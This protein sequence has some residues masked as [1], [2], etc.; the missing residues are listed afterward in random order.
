MILEKFD[1]GEVYLPSDSPTAVA[2]FP[3][4]DMTRAVNLIARWADS[5]SQAKPKFRLSRLKIPAALGL[6]ALR[7]L[8]NNGTVTAEVEFQAQSPWAKDF[9]VAVTTQHM[10]EK[11]KRVGVD[12]A[13]SAY[14]HAV[15]L[16]IRSSYDILHRYPVG[17]E[18]KFVSR[19]SL[20][21]FKYIP[22]A[23]FKRAV[24]EIVLEFQTSDKTYFDL[25]ELWASVWSRCSDLH[26]VL[27]KDAATAD[28]RA[29][30]YL[31]RRY[32]VAPTGSYAP[33]EFM[34]VLIRALF[35]DKRF[36]GEALL[37]YSN[38]KGKTGP[39]SGQI[40]DA[41]FLVEPTYTEIPTLPAPTPVQA[42]N[43]ASHAADEEVS[44]EE[45]DPTEGSEPSEDLSAGGEEDVA[46]DES[47][48]EAPVDEAEASSDEESGEQPGDDEV[49]DEEDEVDE[50]EEEAEDV[51]AAADDEAPEEAEAA[52][53]EED[54]VSLQEVEPEP[55]P[56]PVRKARPII[57]GGPSPAV[58]TRPVS[59]TA[60]STPED[61]VRRP[62]RARPGRP[63]PVSDDGDE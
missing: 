41:V 6:A 15:A 34:L 45:A 37:C 39:L 38:T 8:V 20:L 46:A 1:S 16:P 56:E 4:V 33:R 22:R 18:K 24:E 35:A 44:G 55:A 21:D 54:E 42:T 17:F 43:G 5:C 47:G 11:F 53:P 36:A 58:P 9:I 48:E 59:L 13:S 12:S 28:P 52:A 27:L 25:L 60:A 30:Q 40:P 62:A 63:A 3:D 19:N 14:D 2:A 26:A 50:A 10:A 49:V 57:A 7:K 61:A 32:G 31:A 23:F 51:T 29:E